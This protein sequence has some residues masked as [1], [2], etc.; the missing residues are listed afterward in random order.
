MS[1]ASGAS[2]A[3]REARPAAREGA[4]GPPEHEVAPGYIRNSTDE[5]GTRVPINFTGAMLDV[6]V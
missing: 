2:D 3:G 4:C 1:G 5:T 6:E